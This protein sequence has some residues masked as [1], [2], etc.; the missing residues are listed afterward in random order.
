MK[1]PNNSLGKRP[2][3]YSPFLPFLLC[4][5]IPSFPS[6]KF[7]SHLSFP[8]GEKFLHHFFKLFLLHLIGNIFTQCFNKG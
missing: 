7:S 4:H 8:K 3:P 2:N 5:N 6:S 1:I